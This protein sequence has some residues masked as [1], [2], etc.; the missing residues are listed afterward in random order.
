M[1]RQS[2]NFSWDSHWRWHID[3][4]PPSC[5][6]SSLCPPSPPPIAPIISPSGKLLEYIALHF[7]GNWHATSGAVS[8]AYLFL[9]LWRGCSCDRGD[10]LERSRRRSPPPPSRAASP[11]V[12]VKG[13]SEDLCR[14]ASF[15]RHAQAASADLSST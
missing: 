7:H 3:G 4:S 9:V 12:V 2:S 14:R 5:W 15:C 11:G 13:C 6:I 1:M 10:N 8:A